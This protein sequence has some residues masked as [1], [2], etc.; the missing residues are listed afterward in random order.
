MVHLSNLTEKEIGSTCHWTSVIFKCTDVHMQNWTHL[1][2]VFF[3]NHAP[4]FS[5][6]LAS[7][8]QDGWKLWEDI[9]LFLEMHLPEFKPNFSCLCSTRTLPVT[10]HQWSA[11]LWRQR[12]IRENQHC[13]TPLQSYW[14]D[15][16]ISSK[17]K[18]NCLLYLSCGIPN[19]ILEEMQGLLEMSFLT[20]DSVHV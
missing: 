8:S 20:A 18:A 9:Y 4:A 2:H 1:P 14:A 7:P 11:T 15:V 19:Y 17:E 13:L 3:A 6:V 10:F 12:H 16:L 5:R